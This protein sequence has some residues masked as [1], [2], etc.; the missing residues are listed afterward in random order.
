MFLKWAFLNVFCLNKNL[1]KLSDL[2][3][4]LLNDLNNNKINKAVN[5]KKVKQEL[6]PYRLKN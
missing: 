4:C 1:N 5:Q 6:I 3:V 2:K